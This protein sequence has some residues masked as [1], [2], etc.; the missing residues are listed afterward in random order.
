MASLC[1]AEPA[2]PWRPKSEMRP[3]RRENTVHFIERDRNSSGRPAPVAAGCRQR[4]VIVR[5]TGQ[6]IVMSPPLVIEKDQ[7]DRI[8][9]ALATELERL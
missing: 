5:A 9:E 1:E 2:E 3:F 6:K 4:G 7:I 8:V